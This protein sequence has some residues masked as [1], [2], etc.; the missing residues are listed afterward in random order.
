MKTRKAGKLKDLAKNVI[1]SKHGLQ[2]CRRKF[3]VGM[4]PL[5]F[6]LYDVVR[7]WLRAKVEEYLYIEFGNLNPPCIEILTLPMVTNRKQMAEACK[8]L[9]QTG[10]DLLLVAHSSYCPSGQIGPELVKSD[11]PLVLW[12]IQPMCE[13]NVA[14]YDLTALLMNHGVHGTMDLANYLNRHKRNYGVLHGHWK[15]DEF[16]QTLNAW[17][18]AGAGIMAMRHSNPVILGSRFADMLDIRMDDE[19]FIREL[20]VKAKMLE[21]AQLKEI[22]VKINETDI[23]E[24]VAE[25]QSKFVVSKDATESFLKKTARNELALRRILAVY[26]SKAIGVNFADVAC[27][28]E[29]ADALQVAV[30]I[31]MSEGYGYGGEGD[32]ETAMFLHSIQEIVGYNIASFTEIFSV[33]YTDAR[34][35]LRHMGE[36]NINLARQK[37]ELKVNVLDNGSKI[38]FAICDFEFKPGGAILLNLNVTNNSQGQL[39]SISGMIEPEHLPKTGGVKAIFKPDRPVKEVLNEYATY[40]GS[41]HMVVVESDISDICQKMCRLSGW[42]YRSI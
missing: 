24:K 41:H 26:N 15:E 35:V 23:N 3:K 16:V 39:I 29:L 4:I 9:T 30:S 12:P 31:L 28:S 7:P 32:W 13:I 38:E 8:K 27:A 5:F 34:L 19:D 22:A 37:P 42:K 2:P 10:I 6:E 20:R 21:L 14:E 33:G 18:S 40:G 25:Y 17:A 1:E 36:G 11:L